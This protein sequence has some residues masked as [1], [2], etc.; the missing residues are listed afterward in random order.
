[1]KRNYFKDA[2]IQVDGG[3]RMTIFEYNHRHLRR[4]DF[5][6]AVKC[7]PPFSVSGTLPTRK[8]ES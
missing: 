2:P 6:A 3:L 4:V 8:V 5:G 7:A 1:M